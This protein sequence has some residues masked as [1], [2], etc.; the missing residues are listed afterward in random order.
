MALPPL[1]LFSLERKGRL[2]A[3]RSFRF[4]TKKITQSKLVLPMFPALVSLHWNGVLR[5]QIRN[6]STDLEWMTFRQKRKGS[7]H[8][9]APSTWRKRMTQSAGFRG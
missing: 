1:E 2:F 7:L 8:K 9:T 4:A 3:G 6:V 5:T